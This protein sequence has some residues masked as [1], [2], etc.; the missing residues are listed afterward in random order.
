MSYLDDQ[1]H[2]PKMNVELMGMPEQGKYDK[3]RKVSKGRRK[4]VVVLGQSQ[5]GLPPPPPQLW[6]NY[7]F[8][9]GFFNPLSRENN[10]SDLKVKFLPP[11]PT[12]DRVKHT[13]CVLLP[14]QE[15]SNIFKVVPP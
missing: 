13:N 12:P 1:A 5:N 15:I 11:S 8:F 14:F 10:L 3:L 2:A 7:H 6:S 9:V 4:K